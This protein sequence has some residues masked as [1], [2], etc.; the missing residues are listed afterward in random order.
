MTE[1]T[2]VRNGRVYAPEDLGIRDVLVAGERVVEIGER[3]DLGGLRA[4]KIDAEGHTVVPGL[5]DGHLHI[6]GGGGNE[7][8]ASRIPELWAGE[9]ALAG[10]TTVVA[11]PGL[12]M[13]TKTVDG[14]LAKAYALDSEGVTAYMMMGGFQRPF[15]TFSGSIRRDIFAIE[16][17]LGVKVALGETRA[18]RFGD[19]ELIELAAQLHW[20]AGATGKACVLHAHLG[21]ANDP[22]GQLLDTMRRSGV[23]AR[24]F[25][26]THCNYTPQTMAAALEVAAHGGFVDF[27]PILTPEFGHPHATPVNEAIVRSLD[28]GVDEHLVTMT[29]DGNASVPMA[30]PDG[31]HGAYEKSLSWLWEAVVALVRQE[32]LSLPRALAFATLNPARALGLA[33]KGRVR[34]GGDAD[35]LVIGPDMTIRHV[36][37]RGNHLVEDGR[38]TALS[39]YE[40]GRNAAR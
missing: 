37:A 2:V 6:I 36:L 14:I 22:A 24:H 21:E 25:Q 11:P 35:L 15:R 38:A 1:L 20:L 3:L 27:N 5:V 7:G 10:L 13:L 18:S 28:A 19:G 23:P 34:V 29:T 40:P 17:I 4:K 9:L 31:T 32:G 26:A 33:R 30:M 12:D 8:Y 16:K 39:L